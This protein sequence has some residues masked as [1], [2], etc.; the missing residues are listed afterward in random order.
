[1]SGA[2]PKPHKI[3][4]GSP[5]VTALQSHS[6]FKTH[7]RGFLTLLLFNI[8]IMCLL[9]STEFSS[10]RIQYVIIDLNFEEPV[11]DIYGRIGVVNEDF[12]N[13]DGGCKNDHVSPKHIFTWIIFQLYCTVCVLD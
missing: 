13:T 6:L 8:R 2:L 9:R 11:I 3:I 12:D 7:G 10:L 5:L 4:K 1:M